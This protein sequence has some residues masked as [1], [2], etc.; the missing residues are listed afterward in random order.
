MTTVVNPVVKRLGLAGGRRS[1]WGAITVVGRLSGTDRTIAILPRLSGNLVVI[2]RSYG[3]GVN[4]VANVL[5]AGRARIR[6]KGSVFDVIEPRLIDIDEAH[7][8]APD[9]MAASYRRMRV[10]TFMHVRDAGR[11]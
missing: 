1:G 9:R 8:H 11:D 6:H 3:S 4:W 7:P 5:A 10:T 2:P